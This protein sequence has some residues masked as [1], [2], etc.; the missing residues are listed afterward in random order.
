MSR[1]VS[2]HVCGHF[3][4]VLT[5]LNRAYVHCS[6]CGES[7]PKQGTREAAVAAWNAITKAKAK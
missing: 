6:A 5:R 3:P 1:P 7:G 4:A 2:C